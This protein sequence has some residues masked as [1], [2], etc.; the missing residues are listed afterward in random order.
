MLKMDSDICA[1]SSDGLA[2]SGWREVNGLESFPFDTVLWG[3]VQVAN[4]KP[5][6]RRVKYDNG[7]VAATHSGFV[8]G[9]VRAFSV[10]E[11]RPDA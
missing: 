6:D 7:K 2:V 10:C 1:F 11:H 3:H 5:G 4:T 8:L 9:F